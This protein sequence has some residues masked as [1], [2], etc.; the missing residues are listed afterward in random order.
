MSRGR[1]SSLPPPLEL[2]HEIAAEAARFMV[3]HGIQDFGLAK[4]KAAERLGVRAAGLALPT[5]EQVHEQVVQWQRTFEPELSV[6]RLAHLRRLAVDAM[7]WLE[8]F[9]PRLVGAVLDG[10]ATITTAV[11]LHVFSDAP[12]AVAAVL[13]ERGLRPR[14][15]QRRYRTGKDALE[16]V[17]GFSVRVEGEELEVMVFPERGSAHAPRSPIDG[18]P[19]RRASRAAVMALLEPAH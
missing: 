14:D 3:E 19:M 4:R 6:G 8:S 9:R 13:E 1:R 2:R 18:R 7:Q 11:E 16:Q 12:E 10:T 15:S 5:N 17:P